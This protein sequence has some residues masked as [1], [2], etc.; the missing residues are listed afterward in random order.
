MEIEPGPRQRQR[1]D[2]IR[3]PATTY[4]SK[5]NYNMT[6][7]EYCPAYLTVIIA[8]A[9]TPNHLNLLKAFARGNVRCELYWSD[10]GQTK[11]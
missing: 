9:V 8:V 11:A 6:F 5:P 4:F 10:S 1:I 3:E 7:D 2:T